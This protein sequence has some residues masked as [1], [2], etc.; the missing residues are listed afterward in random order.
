[1]VSFFL[2]ATLYTMYHIILIA[3]NYKKNIRMTL[4]I[5]ETQY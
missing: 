1:M 2:K 4:K 3:L 5:R